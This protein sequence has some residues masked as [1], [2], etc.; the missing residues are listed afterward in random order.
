M[1]KMQLIFINFYLNLHALSNYLVRIRD[2]QSGA[3]RCF[4]CYQGLILAVKTKISVNIQNKN[5]YFDAKNIDEEIYLE[6]G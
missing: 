3:M 1:R 5:L 2:L 6:A 4:N